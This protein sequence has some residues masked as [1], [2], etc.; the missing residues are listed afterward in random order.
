MILDIF[1]VTVL[2]IMSVVIVIGAM[3]GGGDE[4]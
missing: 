1:G 3:I 4:E 2:I